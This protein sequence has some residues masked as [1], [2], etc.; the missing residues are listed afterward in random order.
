MMNNLHE[1][2]VKPTLDWADPGSDW[3]KAFAIYLL[4][5]IGFNT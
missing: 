1:R 2:P 3:G 5:Q 4:L